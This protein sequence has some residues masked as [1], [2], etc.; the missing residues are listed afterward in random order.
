[1]CNLLATSACVNP[2]FTL[3]A[4]KLIF[5]V[6]NRVPPPFYNFFYSISVYHLVTGIV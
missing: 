1:M 5:I 3:A 6:F 4:A 2:A